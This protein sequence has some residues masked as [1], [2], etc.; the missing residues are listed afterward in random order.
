MDEM[1]LLR[2]RHDAQP[3]PSPELIAGARD[4]LLAHTRPHRS[5]F[6]FSRPVLA[7]LGVAVTAAA[8]AV[9]IAVSSTGTTSHPRTGGTDLSGREILL[10]AAHQAE[11]ASTTGTYWHVKSYQETDFVVGAN[12]DRR[13]Y[14]EIWTKPNGQA[15]VGWR[16]IAGAHAGTADV[17]KVKGTD[18]F[19][20][21]DKEMTFKQVVT[22]PSDV[23][24][25]KAALWKAM[26]NN[27]DGPVP[28]GARE[29]F[30]AGCLEQLLVDVPATPKIRA[31]AFRA[32]A[33]TPNIKLEGKT[34]DPRGRAGIGFTIKANGRPGTS[35]VVIDPRTSLV[36]SRQSALVYASHGVAAD[37]KFKKFKIK[38]GAVMMRFNVT[39]LEVGWTDEKPHVPTA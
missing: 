13:E 25:L 2:D 15:W 11:L 34:T 35:R 24:G 7:G 14:S 6:R 22:L 31:A 19:L 30:V 28:A 38:V 39:Y 18:T 36:L 37:A 20:V 3:P 9:A 5:T 8:A 26:Q 4:R 32:L 23:A 27:D 10:A 1:Q 12:N 16:Q 29:G 21:C 17:S 33:G